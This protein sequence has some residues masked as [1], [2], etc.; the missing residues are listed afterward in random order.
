MNAWVADLRDGDDEIIA[1][2]C[3]AVDGKTSRRAHGAGGHPLHLVSAWAARQRLVLGQEACEEKGNE[4]IAVPR[5][6][7]RLDVRGAWVK[8]RG[9]LAAPRDRAEP[10]VHHFPGLTTVGVVEAEVA[11]KGQITVRAAIS[12]PPRSSGLRNFS[13]P[14]ARIG[15]SKIACTGSW[16]WSSTTSARACEPATGRPTWH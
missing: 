6:L 3:R 9:G 1:I 11:H 2:P 14:R 8:S 12:F 13:T 10:G 15:G 4:I 16:T 5:F 7:A